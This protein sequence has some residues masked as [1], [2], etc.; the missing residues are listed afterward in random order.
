MLRS[1]KLSAAI[2]S[3]FPAVLTV[4]CII[5]LNYVAQQEVLMLFSDKASCSPYCSQTLWVNKHLSHEDTAC[6][7]GTGRAGKEHGAHC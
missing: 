2:S 1:T 3:V 6:L 5:M 7:G 4:N